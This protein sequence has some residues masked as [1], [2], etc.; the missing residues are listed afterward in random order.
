MT[1]DSIPKLLRAGEL[2]RL[3]GVS[4]DTLRHY[5][6]V[7]VLAQPRRSQAGYR[8]Y[9]AEAAT[10]V[11]L[12][13]RALR[14]GFTLAELAR[15]LRARDRGGAPCREVRALAAMK[16]EQLEVRLADLAG[17]RDHLRDLLADWDERL[18]RTPDGVRAGLLEVLLKR[19]SRIGEM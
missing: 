10:R 6:R 7:G 14:L 9:P 1:P 18:K 5:E 11:Q 4:T 12:V 19:P 16:L 13:R 2:A 8:L 17:L 15:I 3:C